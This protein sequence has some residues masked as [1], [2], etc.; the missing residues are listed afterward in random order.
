MLRLATPLLTPRDSQHRNN[1]VGN[2][3]SARTHVQVNTAAHF[4]KNFETQNAKQGHR[5]ELSCDVQG[6]PPISVIWT[7]DREPIKAT[8]YIQEERITESA[9][10]SRIFLQTADISDSAFFTCSASNPFGR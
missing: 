9:L 2:A 4:V 10:L 1:G 6:D 8:K 3:I 7:K 5:V